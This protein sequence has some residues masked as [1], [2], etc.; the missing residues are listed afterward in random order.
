MCNYARLNGYLVAREQGLIIESDLNLNPDKQ[1][2]KTVCNNY[3]N[4]IDEL[5]E[6]IKWRNKV[7]AHFALT[8]P[9]SLDNISTLEASII[10]PI[11]FNINRFRTGSVI[12]S[13]YDSTASYNS[14]IP[15]WSLTETFE[16]LINRFWPDVIIT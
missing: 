5:K 7:S 12:I 9:V 4:S 3:I 6:V 8:Y 15:S 16:K 2:I 13:K 14:E 1:K 11:G 10:Y